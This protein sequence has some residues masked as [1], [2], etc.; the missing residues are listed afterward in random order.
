MAVSSGP[1]AL[2]DSRS[3]HAL[4]PAFCVPAADAGFGWAPLRCGVV[5][6]TVTRAS[7]CLTHQIRPAELN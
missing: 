1:A 4:A 7:L 5:E 6:S 3:Q 2:R